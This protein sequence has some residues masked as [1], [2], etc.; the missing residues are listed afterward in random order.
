M[1][2]YILLLA[3]FVIALVYASVGFGGGS[4]YLALL[5]Q[6]F[7]LLLP[8]VIRPT[9]LLC[10]IVVVTGGTIVFYREGKID[11][12]EVWPF[13][14]ASVPFALVGGMWKLEQNV[15]F[16][17]LAVSLLIAAVLLWINPTRNEEKA[18]LLVGVPSKMVLSGGIGFLSGLVSIG[19]GIFLSPILHLLNWNEAKRIS[20]LASLFI[21][22]NSISGLTGQWL[23]GGLHL[24]WSFLLPL[25]IAVLAGGQIGSRL[26]AIKFNPIYIKRITAVLIFVAAVHILKDHWP[27]SNN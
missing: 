25:L 18:S 24:Q 22:V 10:N 14:V 5:A 2:F 7:F 19:G 4:S 11:W 26:G 21:L 6:P 3:F 1:E 15:F 20:A 9:A 12:K 13:L 8:D 23:R 17:I 27:I 16:I